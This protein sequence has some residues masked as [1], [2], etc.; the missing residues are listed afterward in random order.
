MQGLTRAYADTPM[1]EGSIR[2]STLTEN[3][4]QRKEVLEAQLAD[5]NAALAALEKNPELQSLFDIVSRVH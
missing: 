2:R 1:M 4:K 3:I 5:L